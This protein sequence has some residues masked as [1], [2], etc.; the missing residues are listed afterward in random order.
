MNINNTLR[1]HREK[2]GLTQSQLAKM[3]GIV[4]AHYQKLEYGSSEPR[5]TLTRKL[6]KALNVSVEK[7]FPLPEES[8]NE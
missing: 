5:A 2:A 3:V 8:T 7:L 4:E 1:R 6:A